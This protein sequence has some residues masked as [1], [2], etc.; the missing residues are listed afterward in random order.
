MTS[1]PGGAF[2]AWEGPDP[3]RDDGI[4]LRQLDESG[5]PVDDE[6]LVSSPGRWRNEDASLATSSDGIV[7]LLSWVT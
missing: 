7:V 1:V 3:D 6:L 5:R 2:L 4:F